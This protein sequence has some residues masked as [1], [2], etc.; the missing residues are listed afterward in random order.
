MFIHPSYSYS[1]TSRCI[2]NFRWQEVVTVNNVIR[3]Y[4][5]C[6]TSVIMVMVVCGLLGFAIAVV[7][8]LIIV[9]FCLR[10]HGQKP[11]L[12]N[13]QA[14]YKMSLAVADL[15]VGVVVLPTCVANMYKYYWIRHLPRDELRRVEGYE[16][17]NGT[18]SENVTVIQK[19]F[20]A[21]T[22]AEKFPQSYINFAGFF[23]GLSLFV[24]VYMLTGAGFDRLNAVAKPFAY[25]K[26]SAL[27]ESTRFCIAFWIIAF[28]LGLLPVFVQELQYVLFNSLLFVSSDFYGL[29]LYAILFVIPLVI[30]WVVNLLTYYHSIKH[31]NFRRSLTQ[32]ALKK[33]QR[34]ER[35]LASTLRLMVGV[36]TFNTLP[37][38]ITLIC[39]LFIPSIVP[40]T[41]TNFNA[42]SAIAFHTASFVAIILL[43]G[44]SLCNFFI[45]SA[46]NHEF[47][48]SLKSLFIKIGKATK[49]SVCLRS[50]TLC[51][52]DIARRSSNVSIPLSALSFSR[53]RRSTAATIISKLDETCTHNGH[54]DS[55]D[56]FTISISSRT[57]T[58]NLS[59]QRRNRHDGVATNDGSGAPRKSKT[60]SA[61]LESLNEDSIFGTPVLEHKPNDRSNSVIEHSTDDSKSE[62]DSL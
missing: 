36:F 29:I 39:P 31:A 35:R 56:V 19:E 60:F 40:S 17:I 38:I 41:P 33:R 43:L 52:R 18:L 6:Q 45:Y 20:L 27:A 13:S 53:Q 12:K 57:N 4:F 1:I 3:L 22:F 47:R 49:L 55:S 58:P 26:V 24:S 28:I 8:I 2:N 9:V 34:V 46:R 15:L 10:P 54:T 42:K 21:G 23:T 59:G 14:V 61:T 48:R 44:N 30:V 11:L 37:L 7:N 50:T 62:N 51:F 32:T 25:K 5:S 16:V